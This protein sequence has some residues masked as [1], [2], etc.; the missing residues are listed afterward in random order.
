MIESKFY[1]FYGNLLDCHWNSEIFDI[2]KFLTK[3]KKSQ[4]IYIAYNPIWPSNQNINVPLNKDLYILGWGGELIDL[5]W[6]KKLLTQIPEEKIILLSDLEF[7]NTKIKTFRFIHH[8][9]LTKLFESTKS[10][11]ID[12]KN[13]QK[14]NFKSS[15]L[16]HRATKDKIKLIDLLS[17]NK[18]ILHNFDVFPKNITDI[19]TIKNSL[20]WD[21]D[22]WEWRIPPFLDCLTNI[23][24][25]SICDNSSH[26][27][28]YTYL[29]EKSFKP[30][31]AGCVG[32]H[33][34]QVN[35]YKKLKEYGFKTADSLGFTYDTIFN[36]SSR[37]ETF[38]NEILH[39]IDSN[40]D[41]EKLEEIVLHNYNYYWNDFFDFISEKN[42]IE[43][44]KC[45]DYITNIL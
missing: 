35:G 39:F 27:S 20:L 2:Y 10:H 45:I 26:F 41:Y 32:L 30:I 42:K 25:E 3:L 6:I 21:K 34:G 33:Y 22:P 43:E 7:T 19:K 4:N 23:T 14:R 18:N 37:F 9:Y 24:C 28:A 5:M 31:M 16:I 13:Y 11:K 15:V 40:L 29:T 1:S 44:K 38:K 17:N 36:E 12:F 8:H